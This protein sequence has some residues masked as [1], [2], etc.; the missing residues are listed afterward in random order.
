MTAR[1]S[2]YMTTTASEE[3]PATAGTAPGERQNPN[4]KPNPAPQKPR[5]APGKGK[6]GKKTIPAEKATKA[7]AAP[8]GEKKPGAARPGSKTA[9][10]LDLLGRADGA[11][12]KEIVKVTGWQ[13]HSVR[14]F[15]SGVLGKKMGLKVESTARDD[16][17]RS[18]S[19]KK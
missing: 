5:V 11:T 9:K 10:V 3:K 12:L 1:R 17:E 18:Y 13:P 7:P 4:K 19:L 15:I 16:G 2:I 8:K 14:G 6:S